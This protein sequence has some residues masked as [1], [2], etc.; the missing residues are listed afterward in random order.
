MKT[1]T[2][3]WTRRLVAGPGPAGP[4]LPGEPPVIVG[5]EGTAVYGGATTV[6]GSILA[7]DGV[8][9][10][11]APD[12]VWALDAHDG[13]LLWRY[14]WRTK[15][16][17]HIGNRGA[18][19]LDGYLFFVTPDNYL[20]SLDART[21]KERWRKEIASFQQQYF[22]T[23][24]PM[25]IDNHVL[26]GSSNDLDMPGFLQ[27]F[28]PETGELQWKWYATP[29]K[30]GDPGL[31]TWKSLDA[32]IHGGGHPWVPGVLR[33]GD[34][35]LH[36]RH[37]QSDAGLHLRSARGRARQSLH[38]R[39][40]GHQRRHRQ[41]GVV[42]PDVAARHARLGLGADAG[43]RRRPVQRPAAQMVVTAAR[44][45]Y[46]FVVDRVTGEH[47]LTSKF[48]D[49]AN[50]ARPELNAKGQPVRIPEKD[51]HIVG[52]AGVGGEPGRGQL[53]AAVV[54]P[55]D[56][57]VLRAHGRN[58]RAVLPDR[59]RPARRARAWRQGGAQCRHDRQLPHRDRLQDRQDRLEAASTAPPRI[60][61]WPPAC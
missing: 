8:L 49:S 20:I 35:A 25:V 32:A 5:G 38:L 27:S 40:G 19:M 52:R 39:A 12:N 18:G 23:M 46:F 3:A 1:L 21:G 24:A 42:L 13:H 61:A 33:S 11:T 53:A 30:A 60:P 7:V 36:R 22:H 47:L 54:Q 29:Q 14:F 45:G 37:G 31:E 55:A 59:A 43:A 34:P 16:G 44:N 15:G 56:R 10:V 6:K 4:T 9:Y 51:H 2:L 26:V 28:D 50:W 17:T 58:L 57:P 41:D 48:S